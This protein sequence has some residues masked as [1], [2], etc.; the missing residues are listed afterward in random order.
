[1]VS[2]RIEQ[3]DEINNNHINDEDGD[4]MALQ[5]DDS[6]NGNSEHGCFSKLN[7]E[8]IEHSLDCLLVLLL[9]LR[10][11]KCSWAHDGPY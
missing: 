10:K 11:T 1:M 9:S 8:V 3:L 6:T 4:Y 7:H 2:I 5:P